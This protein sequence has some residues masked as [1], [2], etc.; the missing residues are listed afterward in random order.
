MK[1]H[2]IQLYNVTE[3]QYIVHVLYKASEFFYAKV[4]HSQKS[5]C[6]QKK[7]NQSSEGHFNERK[8]VV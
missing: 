3:I 6:S 7:S 1:C 8:L 2:A 4:L 5:S